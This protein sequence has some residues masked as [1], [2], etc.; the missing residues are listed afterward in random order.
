[1]IKAGIDWGSSSLRAYR[2][3]GQQIIDTVNSD[4]GIKTFKAKNRDSQ[5]E[6]VLFNLIGDW[7]QPGDGLILSGMITSV[8]GWIETP[9][10]P[11]P[12]SCSALASNLT[13]KTIREYDLYFVSGVCQ[14][15]PHPDVM[16]G[17]ELQL[18]GE[19]TQQENMLVIMPGTHSKWAQLAA[20]TIENF[21]TIVTGELFDVLRNQTLIGQL[22]DGSD[23]HEKAFLNGI[24]Q[25]YRS[26]TII[27]DLFT[28]RSG[29]LLQ[30]HNAEA[31]HS[32]LSGLLIGNEIREGMVMATESS[33]IKLIGSDTLCDKYR[34]ALNH[35]SLTTVTQ[36]ENPIHDAAASGYLQLMQSLK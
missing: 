11:C 16:R 7:L 25:G 30:H 28:C 24:E 35:L 12:V 27:S 8:N 5:F 21:R 19:G 20:G 13:I 2:F 22:A 17:E 26:Q 31:I 33:M 18:L 29:V 4:R 34:L 9:Y 14:T 1:M 3:D 36:D 6:H 32:Y 23:W 10:L 15:S